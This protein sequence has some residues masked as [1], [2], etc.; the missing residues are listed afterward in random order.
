MKRT[1]SRSFLPTLRFSPTAWAKLVYLRDLGDMEVGGFGVSSAA[2]PLFVQDIRL[3]KQTCTAITVCFDDLAVADYFDEQVDHGLQPAEFARLWI[4]T[5]PGDS[6]QPSFIDE[7]TFVRVFGSTNWALM[8]ILARGGQKY[9]RLRLDAGVGAELVIPVAVDY[10]QPFG[11]S[12][13]SSWGQEYAACVRRA[14]VLRPQA[15]TA[16]LETAFE[17]VAAEAATWPA[18]GDDW[19]FDPFPDLNE[20]DQFHAH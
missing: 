5:H 7:E 6:A 9:A 18:A 20:E 2:D 10:S 15:P 3:I 4:H 11:A 14:E 12:D 17:P 16:P 19:M 13:F 1:R 8:F